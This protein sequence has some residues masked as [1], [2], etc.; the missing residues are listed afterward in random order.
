M[1]SY[2]NLVGFIEAIKASILA[3]P[4][5]SQMA[6]S[7]APIPSS[8]WHRYFYLSL[9]HLE[10]WPFRSPEGLRSEVPKLGTLQD[11]VC[12]ICTLAY[13]LFLSADQF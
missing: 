6:D 8:L 7:V 4:V 10:A 13:F 1:L 5:T 2:G 9:L 11:P 12:S 3:T